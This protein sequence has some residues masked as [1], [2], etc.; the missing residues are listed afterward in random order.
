MQEKLLLAWRKAQF[1]FCVYMIPT[2]LNGAKLAVILFFH[3][4][5]MSLGEDFLRRTR[6]RTKPGL[7]PDENDNAVMHRKGRRGRAN[8]MEEQY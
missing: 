1:K 3:R 2:L 7:S 8:P 5:S 6:R 4:K